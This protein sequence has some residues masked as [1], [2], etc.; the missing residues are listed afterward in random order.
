MSDL[1][2]INEIK[3]IFSKQLKKGNILN[4]NNLYN[5]ALEKEIE[6][7]GIIILKSWYQQICDF[8]FLNN[9]P[10]YSEE[11]FFHGADNS[12]IKVQGN[13]HLFGHDLTQEDFE[14]ML[15]VLCLK[16]SVNW[17][18]KTPYASFSIKYQQ[19]QL[20][21][22]LLHES[23]NPLNSPKAFFRILNTTPLNISL[24]THAER[25]K[26]MIKDKKN[27]LIAGSTGSGKTTL[28]NSL[29][30]LIHK[31]EHI[32]I[33]EDTMEL[34]S[35]NDKCTR[36][37]SNEEYK[38]DLNKLL[39][40]SL[41]ISPDR[42]ILGEMRSHEVSTFLLA[43]NTGHKGMLTTLHANSAKDALDRVALMFM[44][45]GHSNLSY[46]LVLKLVC[47]NI[48]HVIFIEDKKIKEII[49]VFGSESSNV[50]YESIAI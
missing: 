24:Y 11:I 30:G 46:E 14:I 36:L 47:Q 23:L 49:D 25:L 6:E 10:L 44:M 4:W 26:R 38:Q 2:L 31:D 7:A 28:T 22:T 50:F 1:Q 27:I 15:Q 19:I 29:L 45:Y 34:I 5:Y 40:Y 12:E 8:E 37:L 42:I 21:V 33:L 20:R 39:T 13:I 32:L 17:N 3:E 9:L 35:P 16:E 41:R 48:D 43:M 18:Y